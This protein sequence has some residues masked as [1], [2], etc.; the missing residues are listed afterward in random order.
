MTEALHFSKACIKNTIFNCK[1]LVSLFKRDR[2]TFLTLHFQYFN[3]RKLYKTGIFTGYVSQI[4]VYM[5]EV[6]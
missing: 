4:T 1:K 2:I 6:P 3:E 5:L